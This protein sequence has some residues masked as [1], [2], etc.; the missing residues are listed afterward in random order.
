MLKKEICLRCYLE[1]LKGGDAIK[2]RYDFYKRWDEDVCWCPFERRTETNEGTDYIIETYH[3]R[4][5]EDMPPENCPYAL[6]HI[7]NRPAP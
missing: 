7:V 3:P 4:R 1:K 6:E 5:I 2:A